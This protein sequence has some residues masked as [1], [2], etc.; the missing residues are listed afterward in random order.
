MSAVTFIYIESTSE[1]AIK[2]PPLPDK[3]EQKDILK[4][5]VGYKKK[6]SRTESKWSF[7]SPSCFCYR[8]VSSGKEGQSDDDKEGKSII[9]EIYMLF[10]KRKHERKKDK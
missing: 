7:F 10:E 2:K 4:R 1:L 8:L 5:K 6:P 9:L 3:R